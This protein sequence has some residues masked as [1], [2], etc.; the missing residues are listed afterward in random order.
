MHLSLIGKVDAP[1]VAVIVA[2]TNLLG[3]A[4]GVVRER[5]GGLV[6]AISIH[7]L[8]NVGGMLGGIL[9]FVGQRLMR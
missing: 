8:F 9:F 6:P 3:L 1:H 7:V 2:F 5:S 4:A